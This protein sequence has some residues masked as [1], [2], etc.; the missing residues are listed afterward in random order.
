ML[1]HRR[2]KFVF[3]VSLIG[4]FLPGILSFSVANSAVL[5]DTET[6]SDDL[7]IE[8]SKY[9]SK[10]DYLLLWIAPSF[11]FRKGHEDIAAMLQSNNLEVWLADINEALFIPHNSV[12]MRGLSG[13]YVAE[14][15]NK[16]YETT[17]KKIV[18]VSG[19]YGAIPLLRG[20][21]RWQVS[22]P[23]NRYVVGAILFSPNLYESIPPLGTPPQYLPVTK[24][25]NIPIM[26]FQGSMNG[27]RWQLQHLLETLQAGGS[28]VYVEIMQ[29]I[30]GLFYRKER[31]PL[32]DTYFKKMPVKFRNAITLLENSTFDIKSYNIKHSLQSTNTGL[33][34]RLKKFKGNP[35]PLP[36]HLKDADGNL[37]E[38]SDYKNYVT[39][40]NFWATWCPPCV[41]EI[42]S[43]NRLI[44]KM[45]GKPFRLI[46]INYA[47]KSTTIRE[48]LQEVD[49]DFPVL[50]D[51]KGIES[52]KWKVIAFPSTF[53]VAPNGQIHYGVNAGI[54][55]DTPQIIESL[56]QLIEQ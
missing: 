33:D 54:E 9:Q 15:I 36:I 23:A 51:E 24:S 52:A 29:D 50:L 34:A 25:S 10:G 38:I 16:V 8:I 22:Q 27:N 41:E 19:S 47:E 20:A 45:S 46:S 18:L 14:L 11:G 48:F 35:A 1:F 3:K 55:W 28:E 53:V 30:I 49:V 6:L 43:L 56:N 13:D 31:P 40:V 17:G 4:I 39:I 5:I 21:Q 42:P 32:V 26:I 44:A 7:D 37:F 2:F 12:A